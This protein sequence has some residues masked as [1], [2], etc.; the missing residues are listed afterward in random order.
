MPDS[1]KNKQE[2]GK[3]M[4]DLTFSENFFEN[5]TLT[6]NDVKVTIEEMGMVI[7]YDDIPIIFTTQLDYTEY[8]YC[9]DSTMEDDAKK[10]ILSYSKDGSIA[11]GIEE[12][13]I[14][15]N[16]QMPEVKIGGMLAK[17]FDDAYENNV[18]DC[19]NRLYTDE[20]YEYCNRTLTKLP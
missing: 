17:K 10:I 9:M 2:K 19:R 18:N 1:I 14:K 4:S 8:N 6:E 20:F 5:S 7:K 15:L 16:T 3:N 12:M 11:S 13:K